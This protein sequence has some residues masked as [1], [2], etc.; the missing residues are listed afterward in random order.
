MRKR[1]SLSKFGGGSAGLERALAG[2]IA[3]N[4]M[5]SSKL[6]KPAPFVIGVN[7]SIA[8]GKSYFSKKLAA[9]F[10]RKMKVMVLSTDDFIFSN[11]R[12]K[13]KKLMSQKGWP[14]SYNWP[15]VF[16]TLAKIKSRKPVTG[17]TK[18]NQMISDIDPKLKYKIPSNLDVVIIEGINTLQTRVSKK[19]NQLLTD[20]M[21]YTVCIYAKEKY[22]YDWWFERIQKKM[23]GWRRDGIKEHLTSKTPAQLRTWAS[24]IWNKINRP[25][26]KRN[27]TPM[28]VNRADLIVTKTK[29]HG[30]KH[31][32]FKL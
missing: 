8:S 26:I 17:L 13:R 1:L 28:C 10:P 30:I 31:L 6:F 5:S 4:K 16:D 24:S 22:I 7:G 14:A 32:D 20:F 23:K 9:S 21:D 19:Y 3:R 18:Y 2:Y 15:L 25:N 27:I 12:L 11:A 29:T